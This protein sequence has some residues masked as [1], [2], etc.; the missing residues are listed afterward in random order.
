MLRPQN[1]WHVLV[2][3]T[4]LFLLI[5]VYSGKDP[6]Q[7]I[8][9]ISR[10][11]SVRNINRAQLNLYSL[12]DDATMGKSRSET[13]D[14]HLPLVQDPVICRYINNLTQK[15]NKRSDSPFSA[16][17]RIINVSDISTAH[18]FP[19]GHYYIYRGLIHLIKSE[20]EL[21]AVIG[22]E[23]G[24]IAARHETESLSLGLPM[25]ESPFLSGADYEYEADALGAQY[26]RYCGYDPRGGIQLL[27]RISKLPFINTGDGP[28]RTPD[29]SKRIANLHQ[30]LETV[31]SPWPAS[32]DQSAFL[33][34]KRRLNELPAQS[35]NPDLPSFLDFN[36]N[37]IPSPTKKKIRKRG[38]KYQRR[39]P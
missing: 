15:I 5:L 29:V 25:G 31:P 37:T 17:I 8:N 9:R 30:A 1:A 3:L 20:D 6:P 7:N 32:S 22:H 39:H 36:I 24:H 21:A 35:L 38:Q 23:I 11:S 28:K 13:A 26:A 14:R 34:M 19:G 4:F 16:H 33:E 27:T 2:S 18:S 12:Q 10:N